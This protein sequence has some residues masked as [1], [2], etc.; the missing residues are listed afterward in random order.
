MRPN[1]YLYFGVVPLSSAIAVAESFV[2]TEAL[3]LHPNI[4]LTDCADYHAENFTP[5]HF[6]MCMYI[7]SQAG[8]KLFQDFL[9]GFLNFF[10]KPSLILLTT[11]FNFNL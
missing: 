6:T 7:I 5:L 10:I 4:K 8:K 9:A 11:L 3:A 2:A 1:G